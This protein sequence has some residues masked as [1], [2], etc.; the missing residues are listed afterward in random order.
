MPDIFAITAKEMSTK[1]N[2]DTRKGSLVFSVANT[3]DR[4][5]K[6]RASA[7]A[8]GEAKA[9]F[10]VQPDAVSLNPRESK[11]FTVDI[12]VP[13]ETAAGS[14]G[15]KLIVVDEDAPDDFYSTGPVAKFE[16]PAVVINGGGPPKWLWIV[17]AA[18]V[19]IIIGVAAYFIFRPKPLP[20]P[21]PPPPPHAR[22]LH[23]PCLAAATDPEHACDTGLKCAHLRAD[24]ME[25][26]REPTAA[27]Q[28]DA[29]CSSFWCANNKCSKEDGACNGPQDCPDKS[30]CTVNKICRS[31]NE[32][33]CV[34]SEACASGFCLGGFCKPMPSACPQCHPGYTCVLR[35]PMAPLCI[36]IFRGLVV[37]H[38]EGIKIAPM[39]PL[40]PGPAPAPGPVD[41]RAIVPAR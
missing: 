14:Y 37:F 33:R 40:P 20:P 29:D 15:V 19:A 26:R 32:Q 5:V 3:L 18:A 22:Q 38:P 2:P 31:N 12:T 27:C 39:T 1:L 28:H 7:K 16:V 23:D 6:A 41:H 25:C 11:V 13:K 10:K 8:E 21:P 9:T 4:V 35:P 34:Q 30:S 17:L 24:S 36:P